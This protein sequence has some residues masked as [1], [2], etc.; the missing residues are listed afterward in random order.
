MNR[1]EGKGIISRVNYENDKRVRMIRLTPEGEAL[2]EQSANERL[3][4]HN[5]LLVGFTD[6]E[7][8]LLDKLLAKLLDNAQSG[9]S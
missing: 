9:L 4:V 8:E 2:V 5:R 6:K 7:I 3:Q 1:L